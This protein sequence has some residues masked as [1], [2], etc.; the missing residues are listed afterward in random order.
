[1]SVRKVITAFSLALS[2]FLACAQVGAQHVDTIIFNANVITLDR[3]QPNAR[4]LAITGERIAGVFDGA[5]PDTLITQATR[6]I[7]AQ[8][9]TIIP[10]LIDSHIHAIRAGLTFGNEVSF[11]GARTIADAMARLREGAARV[12]QDRWIVVAGGWTPQQFVERRRPTRAEIEAVAPGRRVYVQLF[13]RGAFLS[14]AAQA[15]LGVSAAN[16]PA[17]AAFERDEAGAPN[18]WLTGDVDAITALWERLPKP[19]LDAAKAGTRAFFSTL[20]AFGV[21]G[22]IDPGGHNLAPAEYDAVHELARAQHLSARVNYFISAPERGSELEF[23]KAYVAQRP[24]GSGDAYLRFN[25]I[26]ERV[27]FGMYNNDAPTEADK[28]DF[29]AVARW[30]L[31]SN[32]P[33]TVHWNSQRSV[34]HL[35]ASFARVG[36]ADERARLRWSIAHLHDAGPDTMHAMHRLGLGWLTQNAIYFAAPAFIRN[37]PAARRAAAPPL[38]SALRAG[39]RIAAGTDATRVMSYNPFV[40]MQWML[41]GRTVDGQETRAPDERPSREDALRMWS[42]GGAWFVFAENE[43]GRIAP[44]MLADLAMLDADYMSAPVETIGEIKSV[45]TIVGGRV[46]HASP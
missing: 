19:R 8:G 14:D 12:Q 6:R 28:S 23:F 16:P 17:G 38:G 4:S 33:L 44:G 43:R 11:E 37:M 2:P 3:D 42:E 25:G 15:A 10:G 32:V 46:V 24:I 7:D 41:D 13:Y 26:G 29:E 20:N 9:R 34:H 1:M 5:V 31:A 18:G 40:A 22:V 36:S 35:L 39:L 21:T 45:L 27:T 30:A